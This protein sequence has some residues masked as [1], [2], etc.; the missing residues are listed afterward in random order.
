MYKIKTIKYIEKKNIDLNKFKYQV[1]TYEIS[2]LSSL[3]SK[4]KCYIK[5]AQWFLVL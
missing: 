2:V 5:I 3:T 4:V 1:L